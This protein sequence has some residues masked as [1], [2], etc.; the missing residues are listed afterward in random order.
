MACCSCR[1]ARDSSCCCCRLALASSCRY[2]IKSSILAVS[3]NLPDAFSQ[4]M[5][6]CRMYQAFQVYVFLNCPQSEAPY[7]GIWP[8]RDRGSG[9]LGCSS[10]QG[11]QGIVQ[12]RSRLRLLQQN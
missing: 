11:H 7:V 10:R 2:L 5:H 12:N 3:C 8:S 6:C 1:L 4:A 9:V